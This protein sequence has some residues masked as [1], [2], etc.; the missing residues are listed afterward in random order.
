M[1]QLENKTRRDYIL[2]QAAQLFKERGYAATTMRD[3]AEALDIKAASLYNHIDSKEALLSEICFSF[4]NRYMTALTEIAGS[5]DPVA[6]KIEA[7]IDLH[8][9]LGTHDAA[10]IIITNY[11]WKHLP[12]PQFSA[13]KT[14]RRRYENQFL[15]L[16]TEG[17]NAGMFR[18]L[19]PQ[20]VMFTILSALQWIPFWFRPERGLSVE[21][22]K[23]N[24]KLLII[25]GLK[26]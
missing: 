1:T 13:F 7:V 20:I 17:V 10:A 9:T 5:S 12:E 3:L 23:N 4:A 15:S 11:E 19:D 14:L 26:I 25:N 16:I 18:A 6:A 22:L 21:E 8:I 2:E 24:I